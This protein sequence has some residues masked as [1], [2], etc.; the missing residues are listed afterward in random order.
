MSVNWR[1][2]RKAKKR[3]TTEQS[4]RR[5]QNS[6]S[7]RDQ[8]LEPPRGVWLL[9]DSFLHVE[10]YNS[11]ASL[12][13]RVTGLNMKRNGEIVQFQTI[14]TPTTDRLESNVTFPLGEGYLVQLVVENVGANPKRGQTFVRISHQQGN[15]T[16]SF[17]NRIILADYLENGIGLTWPGSNINSPFA[18]RGLINSFT[19]ANPAVGL[20]WFQTVPANTLWRLI[21]VYHTL[22]TSAVINSRSIGIGVDDGAANFYWQSYATTTQAASTTQSYTWQ[23][24]LGNVY[25]FVIVHAMFGDHTLNAGMRLRSNVTLL[26]GG[27]QLSAI[28]VV[29]EEWMS[30]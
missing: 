28:R 26:D 3:P 24:Q 14:V 6:F 17:L 10:V 30:L 16:A 11:V 13:V 25:G 9:S 12:A 27:D 21:S 22:V 7:V 18:G 4:L 2:R 5:P 1:N 8:S 19:I 20:N 15:A 23:N 29:V